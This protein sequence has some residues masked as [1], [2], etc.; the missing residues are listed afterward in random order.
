MA[1]ERSVRNC[2]RNATSLPAPIT[3][4]RRNK[5]P[6]YRIPSKRSNE[7]HGEFVCATSS[8][9]AENAELVRSIQKMLPRRTFFIACQS[10]NASEAVNIPYWAG[11]LTMARTIIITRNGKTTVITGWRAWLAGTGVLIAAVLLF[12]AFGLLFLGAVISIATFLVIG[13]PLAIGLC[14]LWSWAR[15]GGQRN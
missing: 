1:R 10:Q 13:L 14:V 5:I 11:R 8:A 7:R 2:C 3:M 15:G 9:Y 6:E 12:A 4:L